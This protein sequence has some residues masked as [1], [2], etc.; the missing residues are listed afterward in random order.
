MDDT[1]FAKSL[2]REFMV[3]LDR[4]V[5]KVTKQDGWEVF[6]LALGEEPSVERLEHLDDDDYE[7]L[8]QAAVDYFEDD[9]AAEADFEEIVRST[10]DA[11]S[12]D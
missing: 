12:D 3:E 5:E 4:F 8:G 9:E 1:E 2:G 6:S 10:L 11:H 7:A